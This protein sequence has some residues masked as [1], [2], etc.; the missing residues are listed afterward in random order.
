MKRILKRV[1]A[2]MAAAA[3]VAGGAAESQLTGEQIW[4]LEQALYKLGYH[5]AECDM[6]LDEETKFPDCKRS[7]ADRRAGRPDAAARQLR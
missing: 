6:R 3:C 5:S 1:C 7:G 2:A 4:Q